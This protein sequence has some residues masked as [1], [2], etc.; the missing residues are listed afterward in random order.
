M[1][2]QEGS[3]H[4]DCTSWRG[5]RTA[6]ARH[7]HWCGGR[8]HRARGWA[9]SPNRRDALCKGTPQLLQDRALRLR[10]RQA[11]AHGECGKQR[12]S[13]EWCMGRGG[14]ASR[15]CNKPARSHEPRQGACLALLSCPQATRPSQHPAH[16]ASRA[17]LRATAGHS[18]GGALAALAN[19]ASAFSG[20]QCSVMEKNM[21]CGAAEQN[22]NR[23]SR[24]RLQPRHEAGS[25]GSSSSASHEPCTAHPLMQDARTVTVVRHRVWHMT[26]SSSSKSIN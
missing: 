21:F 25:G 12:G 26:G 4:L 7:V 18:S 15:R 13:V 17:R 16:H 9:A 22:T 19:S 2:L 14:Q 23:L 24:F 5:C 6:A 8:R 20:L 10:D 1:S 11:A 3:A